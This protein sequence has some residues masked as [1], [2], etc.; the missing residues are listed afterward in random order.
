MTSFSND[1]AYVAELR[2]IE[3]LIAGNELAPATQSL[4]SLIKAQP[5]D[6]RLFLLGSC[7][8]RANN[9]QDGEFKLAVQAHHLAP[10]WAPAT[11]Q[12]AKVMVRAGHADEALSVA[13]QALTQATSANEH[14]ELLLQAAEIAHQL[15]DHKKTLVWLRVADER[16][17]GDLR[18]R[19]K[20]A[21]SLSAT[22][23]FDGAIAALTPL[24]HLHPDKPA[25]LIARFSAALGA[26]D[27]AMACSDAQALV[28]LEPA[29]ETFAFYLA[30]ARGDN[31]SVI[32]PVLMAQHFD[33]QASAFDQHLVLNL[34]Y[35]LPRD[36]ASMVRAWHPD[37]KVDVLDLGCGTGLLGACL[38]P[39]EGV[40]VGV[41]LSAAMIREAH[42]HGVYHKFHQVDLLDALQATPENQYHVIAALDVL[43][44]VGPLDSL[45]VDALRILLPGGRFVFSCE[46]G[47]GDGPD[48]MLQNTLRFTHRPSYVERV[49]QQAGFVEIGLEERVIRQDIGGPVVGLLVTA[50]KPEASGGKGGPTCT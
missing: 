17:P 6:P 28:A 42:R 31:P 30:Y 11:I 22:A 46:V 49:L 1:A 13:E 37:N 43:V 23:D 40:L 47:P 41:E 21:C 16:R 36:V 39:M 12:L 50:R 38:G 5:H 2:R 44:Y 25:L 18:I 7:L 8:A 33:D 45:T 35:T 15:A 4:D 27:V 26:G 29:N 19:Y 14:V 32:P 34:K 20:I 10:Q 9:N 48:F 3:Q 24:I